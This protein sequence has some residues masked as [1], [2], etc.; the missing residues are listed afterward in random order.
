MTRTFNDKQFAH[1]LALLILAQLPCILAQG[2]I[3]GYDVSVSCNDETYT[4]STCQWDRKIETKVYT[5]D[6]FGPLS[7]EPNNE[8]SLN[9]AEIINMIISK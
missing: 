3:C 9:K 6:Y 5:L 1:L 7:I 4:E 8:V 2:G